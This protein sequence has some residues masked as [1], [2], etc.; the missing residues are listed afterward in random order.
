MT[1][2]LAVL[3][4][5]LV[6]LSPRS[7]ADQSPTRFLTR[8][9]QSEDG[10]PGDSTRSV[11]QARDGYLW[12]ATAEGLVR[13]NGSRFLTFD[14]EPEEIIDQLRRTS[15]LFP[16]P[17]GSVWIATFGN[18][19]LRWDGQRMTSILPETQQ[20]GRVWQVV[21]VREGVI[22]V[23]GPKVV[24]VARDGSYHLVERTPALDAVLEAD[25]KFG[26]EHGR[27][28]SGM[29]NP[30]LRDR[31][32]RLWQGLPS[33]LTVSANAAGDL[34][35]TLVVGPATRY[36]ELHEDREGNIWAATAN[37]GL[38]RLTEARVSM[39]SEADGLSGRTPRALIEDR[40]G[41]LWVG[42]KDGKLNRLA[43]GKVTVFEFAADLQEGPVS[44]LCED[45]T[46]TLWI[47]TPGGG[48]Y[49]RT[50]EGFASFKPPGG[51]SRVTAIVEDKLGRL[52]FGNADGLAM[53]A[54]GALTPVA[55]EAGIDVRDVTA[56]TVDASNTLW[57]GTE[58]GDLFTVRAGRYTHVASS[59][60]VGRKPISSILASEDGV[61]WV[62]TLGAGLLRV[63][64]GL[65]T[66]FSAAQGIPDQRLTCALDDG[67]GRLWLGSLTG[68][69]R[70][71]KAELTEVA[72][73]RRV[74]TRALAFNRSD[75]M[76]SRECMG[77][78]QP[79]GWRRR[80]GSICFPTVHGIAVVRPSQLALNNAVPPI[81]IEQCRANGRT[82]NVTDGAARTGP[83]RSSFDFRY[84]ALSYAAPEKV[85]FRIKL[86]GLQDDW[87]NVGDQSRVTYESVPPGK[88]R[89]HVVGSSGDGVWNDT[90]A[91]M[92][93]EVVP[94]YWETAWFRASAAVAALALLASI[95]WSI[96]RT[97][98]NRRLVK[99]R[100]EMARETERVR[101]ARD[102]HDDL[103]A[104][105]TE[106]SLLAGLA[107]D[108]CVEPKHRKAALPDIA[109]KAHVLA[110][111][112]DEV[113]WAVN[114]SHD[115]VTS[116]AEYLTAFG[117]EY[118]ATAGIT[119]RFDFPRDIPALPLDQTQRHSLFLA[120][121]EA[122]NN[123]VKHSGAR[124]VWLR[125]R[126]ENNVLVL[127]IQDNGCGFNPSAATKGNGIN[128]MSERLRTF[129]GSFRIESTPGSGTIARFSVPLQPRN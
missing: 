32:G 26:I 38:L 50:A 17:D 8:F 90:G 73:G 126:L 96:A 19:L 55:A 47:A 119:A 124:E 82:L 108:E 79:A 34:G 28:M 87:Q 49:R 92:A 128:N 30:T 23:S 121:R 88:Y 94:H 13:F 98:M 33:G 35:P 102:L 103:G 111:S 93:I 77:H 116:L 4:I 123:V 86:E 53:L 66:R 83:G 104:K 61:V 65:V 5:S 91:T 7:N 95:L 18:G 118:L 36:Y 57:V 106:L 60:K 64:G 27:T 107:T 85:R 100:I 70:F 46:G 15:G 115:S 72:E 81:V 10:L 58:A 68:I 51:L 40:D 62:T 67:M 56:L 117:Q 42:T 101:I 113:V 41:A 37:D 16:L 71:D 112:L 6:Y 48:V 1:R 122:L 63:K 24:S 97:R 11:V 120:V 75:G 12:V 99:L 125:L 9:W 39:I 31:R 109:A 25:A 44:A 3:V 45:R 74:R 22:V 76:I 114:P 43:D 14:A 84:I 129:D 54:D 78:F 69:L 21:P 105:L 29:P 110:C 89:F 52:F 59:E 2:I 127:G 80:D 20:M